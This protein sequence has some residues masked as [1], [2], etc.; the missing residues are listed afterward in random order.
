MI[1]PG[2]YHMLSAL[3]NLRRLEAQVSLSVA[4]NAVEGEPRESVDR[5]L[6]ARQ[7]SVQASQRL[8]EVAAMMRAELDIRA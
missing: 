7:L 1:S 4:R 5:Q 6:R 3:A 8:Q 2:T